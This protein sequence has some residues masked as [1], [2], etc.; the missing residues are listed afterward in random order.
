MSIEIQNLPTQGVGNS[1]GGSDV[2]S[3]TDKAQGD[4]KS[5]SQTVTDIVTITSSAVNLHAAEKEMKAV[6]VIDV[7]KVEQIRNAIKNGEYEVDPAK[8]ADKFV[9]LE[10]SLYS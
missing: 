6:P 4:A 2:S 9:S 5:T 3:A 7:E 10:S 1:A 8:I